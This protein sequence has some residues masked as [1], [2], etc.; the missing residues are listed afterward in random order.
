MRQAAVQ[1]LP[2]DLYDYTR[3]PQ[4]SGA[5][6]LADALV[7]WRVIDDWPAQVPVTS[8]EVDVFEAWFGDV[9]DEIFVRRP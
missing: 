2:P 4:D 3:P 8:E 9:I 1:T 7:D 5:K 6:P